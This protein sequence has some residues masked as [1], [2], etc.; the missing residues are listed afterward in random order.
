[1][2]SS[3]VQIGKKEPEI[4]VFKD[5]SKQKKNFHQ[6]HNK[7]KKEKSTEKHKEIKD[8]RSG[9]LKREVSK[10]ALSAYTGKEREQA[11]ES[12]LIKLGAHPVKR[13]KC[14]NY[15]LFLERKKNEKDEEKTK[16]TEK[17][18][19]TTSFMYCEKSWA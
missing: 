17:F 19:A 18:R 11:I 2:A 14:E 8:F 1:M 7:R 16:N 5:P 4:V 9:N 15:K 10:L 6:Q 13:K 12:Y 3:S